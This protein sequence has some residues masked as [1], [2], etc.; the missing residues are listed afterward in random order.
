M[1]GSGMRVVVNLMVV[2]ATIFAIQG[3]IT[4]EKYLS[5]H[6][7][8][9]HILQDSIIKKINEN[10][11]AGWKADKNSRFSNMT[12]GEFR[13]LL[14][15]KPLPHR[16]LQQTPVRTH[17]RS[18]KLPKEFDGRTA[19]SQCSTIGRILDS[20]IIM[21]WLKQGHCGS[22]WAFGAVESLS[23]RFCVHFGVNI[24]LSV[25][26]LLSCCGFLCGSGCDGGYPIFAWRYLM[27]HGVVT[28]E[29]D[30][31]FDTTGCSH[32]GC[33]PGYPTPKCVRKCV[34]GNQMWR[35]SKHYSVSAYR[36]HSDPHDI[37]A[38]VYKNGPVEVSYTVYEDF[39]HYKSGVY[40]HVTGDAL[41]GH[42][43]KLIGW[44][45]SVDGED[46]WLVANQWNR[47]WGDD[48]YF[49]IRRG[50]NECGIEGDVVA[51]L[52]STKNLVR[53]VVSDDSEDAVL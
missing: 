39:A 7:L 20:I 40:K 31:Y 43:V 19:W 32:P 5:Q 23:D 42:A 14:G 13:R 2:L 26:D 50:T 21:L 18:T 6:K 36:V 30:P 45:T 9:S 1:G 16:E 46:Y 34:K 24:S 25:N 51:G 28:E 4:A 37:M 38:E 52:P 33:E 49:K 44:G 27:H 15:V 11:N 10:P 22:C 8:K 12:V 3:Q 41:G 47:S 17:P 53:E 29:C 35:A 48:G